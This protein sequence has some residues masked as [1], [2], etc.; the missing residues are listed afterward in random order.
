M[1]QRT[2]VF[3]SSMRKSGKRF[4]VEI[5]VDGRTQY[6]GMF[7]TPKEAAEAY[8]RAAIQAREFSCHDP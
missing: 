5:K 1:D 4:R 8:D 7:E 2:T 6:L 3:I